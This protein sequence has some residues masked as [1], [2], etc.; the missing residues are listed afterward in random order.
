MVKY[1][2]R[3]KNGPEVGPI[4]ADEFRQRVEAGEI[5]DD[6]T[7][8]RSGLVNWTNY[9]GLRAF[10]EDLA[11]KKA[12]P[13]P[14]PADAKPQLAGHHGA[15]PQP[16]RFV[17]C[18]ACEKEWPENLTILLAGKPLCGNCQRRKAEDPK[19]AKLVAKA[20]PQHSSPSSKAGA[21]DGAGSPAKRGLPPWLGQALTMIAVPVLCCGILFGVMWLRY[22]AKS[23]APTPSMTMSSVPMR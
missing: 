21:V 5:V 3:T 7:V 8:W 22:I 11:R 12:A 9:A 13:P 17:K 1:H 4:E 14:L 6:T 20:V 16:V 10:E 18:V 23:K 2:F 15:A 19:Y